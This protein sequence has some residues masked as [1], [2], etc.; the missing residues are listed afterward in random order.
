M[1]QFNWFVGTVVNVEDPKKRRRVQV[2]ILGVHGDN[3]ELDKNT[4]TGLPDADLPWCTCMFPVNYGGLADTT[5]PP[6]LVKGAQILGISVDGDAYQNCIILGSIPSDKPA[7][8]AC[9]DYN[10]DLTIELPDLTKFTSVYKNLLSKKSS[11]SSGSSAV[12]SIVQQAKE[13][14]KSTLEDVKNAAAGSG[15]TRDIS[16]L[17]E[18]ELNEISSGTFKEIEKVQSMFDEK[19][20]AGTDYTRSIVV[21]DLS[22]LLVPPKEK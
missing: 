17:Q 4:G 11:S 7:D 8:I 3:A 10:T 21:E 6:G 15:V 20:E 18:L 2:R 14:I 16:S 5:P 1:A 12:Q 22:Q 19:L 13:S 9:N